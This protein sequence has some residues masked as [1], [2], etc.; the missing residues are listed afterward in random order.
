MR[1]LKNADYRRI[2]R[3]FLA[4]RGRAWPWVSDGVKDALIDA[5]VM[6]QVRAARVADAEQPIT[7]SQLVEMRH[8]IAEAIADLGFLTFATQ[9][10]AIAR[11]RARKEKNK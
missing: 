8:G 5:E 11:A 6:D 9:D 1:I 2:A 3:E 4:G 7:P 10:G